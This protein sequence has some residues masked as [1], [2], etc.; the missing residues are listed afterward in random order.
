MRRKLIQPTPV[1]LQQSVSQKQSNN[2][3]QNIE[4]QLQLNHHYHHNSHSQSHS[5]SQSNPHSPILLSPEKI[6]QKNQEFFS[7]S[8]Q[9]TGIR[10]IGQF[11]GIE[12]QVSQDSYFP[13]RD[14]ARNYPQSQSTRNFNQNQSNYE[15]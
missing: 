1:D 13:Q 9:S 10:S 4:P 7:N 11:L 8:N 15:T 2:F 12:R 3:Q 14:N 5:H 6:Q